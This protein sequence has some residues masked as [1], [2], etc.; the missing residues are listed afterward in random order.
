MW[1]ILFKLQQYVAEHLAKSQKKYL[2]SCGTNVK[3]RARV[4]FINP[5]HI[6]LGDNVSINQDAYFLGAGGISIGDEVRIGPGAMFITT[7]H[8]PKDHTQVTHKPI[9]VGN[10]VWIGARAVLLPGVSVADGGVVGAGAVVT[11]DVAAHTTVVGVPARAV[12]SRP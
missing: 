8:P 4:S 10:N 6:S 12:T 5:E 7:G 9:S 1:N 3:V 11:K 2:R